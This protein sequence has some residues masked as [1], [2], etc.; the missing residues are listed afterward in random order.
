MADHTTP[1]DRTRTLVEIL[2]DAVAHGVH[3]PKHGTNCACM[4]KLIRELKRQILTVIPT[5]GTEPD[6]EKRVDAGSRVRYVLNSATRY[7]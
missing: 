7:L 1:A 2:D 5:S 3:N 6:W 4:D